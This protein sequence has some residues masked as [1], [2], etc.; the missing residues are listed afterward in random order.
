MS[1]VSALLQGH[2]LTLTDLGRAMPSAAYARH[3]IKRVDRL[4]GNAHLQN[5]RLLF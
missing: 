2:R 3:S 4:L 1:S 5:E